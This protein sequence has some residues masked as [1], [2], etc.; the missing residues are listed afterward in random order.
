MEP[1]VMDALITDW[2]LKYR[3][4]ALWEEKVAQEDQTVAFLGKASKTGTR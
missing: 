3:D 1:S 2:I 4:D